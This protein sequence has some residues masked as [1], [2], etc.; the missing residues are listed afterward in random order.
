M[1]KSSNTTTSLDPP[2]QLSV[3]NYIF[4]FLKREMP[5]PRVGSSLEGDPRCAFQ[6]SSEEHKFEF[7]SD[8]CSSDLISDIMMSVKNS[9][10][11]SFSIPLLVDVNS[12]KNWGE[13]H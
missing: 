5:A 7:Q 11:H 2:N 8:G 13:L 4:F 1:F 3:G 12:G 6:W 10:Q 9:E